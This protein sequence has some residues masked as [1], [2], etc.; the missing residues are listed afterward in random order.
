MAR[1]GPEC[2]LAHNSDS[3]PCD[4]GV[5]RTITQSGSRAWAHVEE[6]QLWYLGRAWGW[7]RLA[8]LGPQKHGNSSPCRVHS[9]I[10]LPGVHSS[11]GC[12]YLSGKSCWQP[13]WSK[14]LRSMLMKIIGSSAVTLSRICSNHWTYEIFSGKGCQGPMQC[15]HQGGNGRQRLPHGWSWEPFP[16]SLFLVVSKHLN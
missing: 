4:V 3:R 16:L 9:I 1:W 5:R 10:S 14:L 15:R 7:Q 2:W 13:L 6:L 12:W 11:Y 8:V